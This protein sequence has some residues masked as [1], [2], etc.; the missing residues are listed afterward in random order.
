MPSMIERHL[1]HHVVREHQRVG[2][3]HPLDRRVRDV[4]LVPQRDVLH[5][6]HEVAAQHPGEPAELLALHRVALVGH[7]GRALLLAG[8]ERLLGLAHLGALQVP[9]LER[10]RL[11]G[12]ADRRAG[13]EQLGVTVAG[14][15]LRGGHRA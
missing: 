13:V 4:A 2:E 6:R 1:H 15:H 12:G 8:A 7:R 14:E 3:H 5:A 9:D 10:E 11:D